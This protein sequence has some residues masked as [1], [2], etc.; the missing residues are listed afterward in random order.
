MRSDEERTLEVD[1]QKIIRKTDII[2]ESFA[3]DFSEQND[4]SKR[5]DEILIMKIKAMRIDVDLFEYL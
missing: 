1:F 4:H 2:F 3:S 5:K